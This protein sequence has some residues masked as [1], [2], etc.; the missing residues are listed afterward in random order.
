MGGNQMVWLAIDD[1]E[2]T[3]RLE[4]TYELSQLDDIVHCTNIDEISHYQ[5]PKRGVFSTEQL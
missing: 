1:F 4:W 2:H 3:A 5:L